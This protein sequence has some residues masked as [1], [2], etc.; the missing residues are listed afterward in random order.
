M[1]NVVFNRETKQITGVNREPFPFERGIDLPFPISLQKSTQEPTGKQIQK[2]N[3]EGQPLYKINISYVP[4]NSEEQT[5]VWEETAEART[6]TQFK[7][8][9]NTYQVATGETVPQTTTNE[10]GEEVIIDVP[11]YAP[12][13]TIS[14]VPTEW[15]DNPPIMVDEMTTHTYSINDVFSQFN[16]SEVVEAKVKGINSN[17]FRQVAYFSEDLDEADFS[18]SLASHDANMGNGFISI[19]PSGQVRTIKLTL[20]K[21]AKTLDVYLEAQP[22]I[23]VEVGA[24]ADAFF[25]VDFPANPLGALIGTVSLNAEASEVYVRFTN[26][27]DKRREVYAFGLLV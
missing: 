16:A 4:G 27:K 15:K 18:T 7:D 13:Q 17:N 6:A 25:L 8:V 26:M 10:L 24:T 1:D 12:L 9:V 22:D 19:N 2:V 21:A 14:Q 23:T 20:P 3:A 11:V 5:E